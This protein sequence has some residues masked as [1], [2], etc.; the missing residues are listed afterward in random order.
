MG[1]AVDVSG[2]VVGGPA[3]LEQFLLESPAFG[4]VDHHGVA[5]DLRAQHGFDLLVA[6]DLGQHRGV[7]RDQRQPVDWALDQLQPAVAVH[8]LGDVHQ[9]RLRHREAGVGDQYV[10]HLLGVVPGGACV[11]QRQRRDAVGV[12]VLGRALEF[13]ERG[14]RLAGVVG[15]VVVDLQQH[16]LVGLDDQR[17]TTHN[18]PPRGVSP[19]PRGPDRPLS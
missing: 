18:W 11:P 13:G 19:G 15:L 1:F 5:V 7:E 14:Q 3:D 10:D 12:H 16:G 6:L 8:G 9:Q 17:S 4:G 2:Q